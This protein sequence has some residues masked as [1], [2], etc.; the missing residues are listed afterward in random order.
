M[1]DSQ[2]PGAETGHSANAV[3]K[4]G[5]PELELGLPLHTIVVETNIEQTV[6]QLPD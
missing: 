4:P 3:P 5:P 6:E 1:D 2:K